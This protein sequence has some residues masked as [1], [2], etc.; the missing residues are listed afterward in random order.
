MMPPRDLPRADETSPG[1]HLTEPA[2][3]VHILF[4]HCFEDKAQRNAQDLLHLLGND[5]LP[6]SLPGLVS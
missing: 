2:R 3:S 4:N 5:E 6:A 1:G